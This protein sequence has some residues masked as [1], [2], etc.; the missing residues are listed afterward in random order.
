MLLKYIDMSCN[1]DNLVVIASNW[2]QCQHPAWYDNLC[3]HPRPRSRWAVSSGASRPVRPPG[4][5]RSGCGS[6]TWKSTQGG[7]PTSDAP[8]IGAS[9]VVLAPVR[10]KP[11]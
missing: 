11:D 2:G 1:G 10:D 9:V 7:P 4:R 5:S 6:G 3:A 8:R